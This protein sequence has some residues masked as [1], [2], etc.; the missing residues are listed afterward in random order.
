MAQTYTDVM[1]GNLINLMYADDET[2]SN[3]E[4]TGLYNEYNTVDSEES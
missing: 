2:I 4:E 3:I 1:V